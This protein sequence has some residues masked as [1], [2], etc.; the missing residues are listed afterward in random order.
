MIDGFEITI[1]AV[2]KSFA[3]HTPE[4]EAAARD[5]LKF[6]LDRIEK[7]AIDGYFY[8]SKVLFIYLWIIIDF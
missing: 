8:G 6:V 1:S 3:N 5:A 2:M 7:V 4:T